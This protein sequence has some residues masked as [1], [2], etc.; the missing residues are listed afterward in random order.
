MEGIDICFDVRSDKM[1]G[2]TAIACCSEKFQMSRIN[3]PKQKGIQVTAVLIKNKI[4]S[5][6]GLQSQIQIQKRVT[7]YLNLQISQLKIKYPKAAIMVGGDRNTIS[8]EELS[9]IYP[10]VKQ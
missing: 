2:G 10:G 9:H 3:I 5:L 4:N 6:N 7:K 8:L 1:G